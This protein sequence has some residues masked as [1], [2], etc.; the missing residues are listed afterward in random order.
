VWRGAEGRT[1]RNRLLVGWCIFVHSVLSPMH[2]PLWVGHTRLCSCVP[3]TPPPHPT[4]HT[5][6]THPTLLGPSPC[7]CPPSAPPPQNRQRLLGHSDTVEDVVFQPGSHTHL[8]SV[9]DDKQVRHCEGGG[10][11]GGSGCAST[12]LCGM[13]LLWFCNMQHVRD[14]MLLALSS[15]LVAVDLTRLHSHVYIHPHPPTRCVHVSPLLRR[16][17]FGTLCQ[18]TRLCVPSGQLMAQA[19]M[20]TASTGAACRNTSLSQVGVG[21]CGGGG[22]CRVGCAGSRGGGKQR[23]CMKGQEWRSQRVGGLQEHLIVKSS[24]SHACLDCSVHMGI[25]GSTT[26]VHNSKTARRRSASVK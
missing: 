13:P 10:A 17:C 22:E 9:G 7:P 25:C 20:C 26:C 24:S 5:P 18:A 14:V 6:A 3:P 4:Q 2:M 16:S 12:G 8:A 11:V 15:K 19:L 23:G 21:V 1:D